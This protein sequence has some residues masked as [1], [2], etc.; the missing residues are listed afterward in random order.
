M[1]GKNLNDALECDTGRL[2]AP[3]PLCCTVRDLDGADLAVGINGYHY[4][5]I[6]PEARAVAAALA[7]AKV[8][9]RCR[10]FSLSGRHADV[11]PLDREGFRRR[12]RLRRLCCLLRPRAADEADCC[13]QHRRRALREAHHRSPPGTISAS[14]CPGSLGPCGIGPDSLSGGAALGR[15]SMK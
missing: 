1:L 14:G 3:R 7:F 13:R 10:D 9:I 4:K 15:V 6:V 5:R 2:D 12:T 11:E 8:K